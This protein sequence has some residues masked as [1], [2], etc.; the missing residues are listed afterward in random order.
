MNIKKR[1]TVFSIYFS[2]RPGEK[3][4]SV[5]KFTWNKTYQN[6]SLTGIT[7][8]GIITEKLKGILFDFHSFREKVVS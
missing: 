6:P 1:L 2:F 4:L 8:H 7:T 5:I 3:K